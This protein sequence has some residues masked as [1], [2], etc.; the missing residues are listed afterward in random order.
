MSAQA[1]GEYTEALDNYYEAFKLEK[2]PNYR[3]YLLY[4]VGIIYVSN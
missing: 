4:K 1:D 3:I 2:H